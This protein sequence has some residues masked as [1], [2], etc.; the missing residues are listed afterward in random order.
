MLS[1]SN[2]DFVNKIY[3]EL[4]KKDKEIKIT[5]LG[6]NRMI[7]SKASKRGKIKEVLVTNY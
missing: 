6:A 1:N 3:G 4:K 7:N 5:K 2:S